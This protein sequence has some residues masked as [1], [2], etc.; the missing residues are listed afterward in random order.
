MLQK[1]VSFSLKAVISILITIYLKVWLEIRTK[2]KKKKTSHNV[3]CCC[4]LFC[5][6]LHAIVICF[7]FFSSFRPLCFPPFFVSQFLFLPLLIYAAGESECLKVSF[8][9]LSSLSLSLSQH[10]VQV[11]DVFE[12]RALHLDSYLSL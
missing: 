11:I 10:N 12:G 3:N 8:P 6:A 9:F 2:K 4:H 5:N 7:G 1:L